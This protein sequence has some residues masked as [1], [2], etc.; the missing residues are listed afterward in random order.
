MA[1]SV[2]LEPEPLASSPPV[3]VEPLPG[4]VS[5]CQ[6]AALA[7]AA[8]AALRRWMAERG[9]DPF[10]HYPIAQWRAYLTQT[11]AHK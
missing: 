8:R 5:F 7:P 10:G 9:H 1:E 6:T 3:E 4:F 11:L 2:G